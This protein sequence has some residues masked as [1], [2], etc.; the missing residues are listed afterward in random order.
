MIVSFVR[1]GSD[2]NG[3]SDVFVRDLQIGVTTL[4][5][6]NATG[7][8]PGNAASYS[9]VIAAGGGYVLFR[10]K[11]TNLAPGSFGGIEN[12]FLRDRLSGTTIAL[13]MGGLSCAAPRN[14]RAFA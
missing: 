2:I 3:A 7:V 11:A 5:S 9:P 10:S 12:L 1:G 13:T 4:V 14:A 8:G 6:V